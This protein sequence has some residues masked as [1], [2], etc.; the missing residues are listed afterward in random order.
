MG[1]PVF[2]PLPEAQKL[3]YYSSYGK[4]RLM[5]HTLCTNHY[6]DLTITFIICINVITMSLEHYSQPH[7]REPARPAKTE[8]RDTC[9]RMTDDSVTFQSSEPCLCYT[10][11]L[12]TSLL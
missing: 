3:P 6:L 11:M 7:V 12:G 10:A 2:F 5:I 1:S 8:L 9:V 4:V